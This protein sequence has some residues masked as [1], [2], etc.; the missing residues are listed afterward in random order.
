MVNSQVRVILGLTG[1]IFYKT[2]VLCINSQLVFY[3][4]DYL[5]YMTKIKDQLQIL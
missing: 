5:Q 4:A 2:P 3:A 1:S